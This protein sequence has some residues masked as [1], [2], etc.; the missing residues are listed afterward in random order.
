MEDNLATVN[1]Q[2]P[3][4]LYSHGEFTFLYIG[5]LFLAVV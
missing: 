3:M 2:R 4:T 1:I 5:I